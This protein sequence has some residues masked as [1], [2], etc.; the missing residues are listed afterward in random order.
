MRE[1]ESFVSAHRELKVCDIGEVIKK[2][3]KSYPYVDFEI[4]GRAHVIADDSVDSVVDNIIRN[5]VMHG[6]ADKILMAIEKSVDTCEVRVADNGL[7]VPDEI[8]KKI[9]EKGFTYGDTA[10]TG[11][12]LHIVEKAMKTYGGCVWVEDNDPKGSVFIMKFKR[13]N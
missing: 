13:V 3:A 7:R 11:I 8:K 4:K 10:H 12:G 5:A 6:K 1:L 2:V 9:F